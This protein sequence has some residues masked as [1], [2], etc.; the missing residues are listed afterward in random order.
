MLRVKKPIQFFSNISPI[1]SSVNWCFPIPSASRCYL[2]DLVP[3]AVVASDEAWVFYLPVKKFLERVSVSCASA[4]PEGTIC[5]ACERSIFD[6][7]Q[8]EGSYDRLCGACITEVLSEGSPFQVHRIWSYT[9]QIESEV[10]ALLRVFESSEIIA[11]FPMVQRKRRSF[12]LE[13]SEENKLEHKR[14]KVGSFGVI[15]LP[16]K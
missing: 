7:F 3:C 16:S 12:C 13:E 11:A 1:G 2:R 6:F 14:A 10:N 5:S 8:R 9:C 4:I 15:E